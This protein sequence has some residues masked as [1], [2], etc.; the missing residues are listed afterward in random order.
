MHSL[1]WSRWTMLCEKL[2]LICQAT[3]GA[4][5]ACGVQD[6]VCYTGNTCDNDNLICQ[7]GQGACTACRAEGQPCCSS[8]AADLVCSGDPSLTCEPETGLCLATPSDCGNE[9]Q[10][11]CTPCCLEMGVC[12]GNSFCSNDLFINSEMGHCEACFREGP[13]SVTDQCCPSL[14][15]DSGGMNTCLVA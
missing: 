5:T 10:H 2:D 1:W 7:L 8:G 3:L 14:V 9:G 15:C 12:K 4:C 6:K 11:S 13:C